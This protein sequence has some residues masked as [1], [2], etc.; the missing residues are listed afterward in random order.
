MTVTMARKPLAN[1]HHEMDITLIDGQYIGVVAC[2]GCGRESRF[3][4]NA[5]HSFGA[6]SRVLEQMADF[7]EVHKEHRG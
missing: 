4:Q 2:M 7:I 5:R 1:P 6:I 3:T